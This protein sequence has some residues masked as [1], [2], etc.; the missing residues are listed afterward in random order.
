LENKTFEEIGQEIGRLVETKN[1]AYGDSFSKSCKI[2]EILFPDGVKPDQYRDLLTMT[3]VIDKMFRIAT[4]KDAMGESPYADIA[5]YSILSVWR[6]NIEKSK[7][8]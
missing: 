7:N 1:A 2:L 6:D 5:G 3:R 8:I 4:D